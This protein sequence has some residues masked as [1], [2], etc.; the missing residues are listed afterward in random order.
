MSKLVEYPRFDNGVGDP[1]LDTARNLIN[2]EKR[3]EVKNAIKNNS[4][5]GSRNNRVASYIKRVLHKPRQIRQSGVR[6]STENQRTPEA[7]PSQVRRRQR[8]ARVGLA[9]TALVIAPLSFA[10]EKSPAPELKKA[11]TVTQ[12]Y[13][14]TEALLQSD[15]GRVGAILAKHVTSKI[16]SPDLSVLKDS[17]PED[18]LLSFT[19][20]DDTPNVWTG[21]KQVLT[22]KLGQVPSNAVISENVE[23]IGAFFKAPP[24]VVYEGDIIIFQPQ[25]RQV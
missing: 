4:L 6:I 1:V 21:V 22:A 17:T 10:S 5:D 20:D 25:E 18:S 14:K 12:H 3:Q 15:N 13:E 2:E 7:K 9:L 16:T 8:F 11:E 24:S 23:A 19:I